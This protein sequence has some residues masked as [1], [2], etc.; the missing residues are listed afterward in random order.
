MPAT[1]RREVARYAPIDPPP[2][3]RRLRLARAV[4]RLRHQPTSRRGEKFIESPTRPRAC[5]EE[6]QLLRF[7]EWSGEELGLNRRNERSTCGSP[8]ATASAGS[9]TSRSS[10]TPISKR[11]C[12]RRRRPSPPTQAEHFRR[13]RRRRPR[14]PDQRRRRHQ[15]TGSRHHYDHDRRLT[16][17]QHDDWRVFALHGSTPSVLNGRATPLGSR[18]SKWLLADV[19]VEAVGD[20]VYDDL[21]V[22]RE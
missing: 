13:L 14:P 12:P 19:G 9:S 18:V 22:L 3:P 16:P 2:R 15:T 7:T 20:V 1:P 10:A 21:H 5:S 11:C 17:P 4:L 8:S 6:A